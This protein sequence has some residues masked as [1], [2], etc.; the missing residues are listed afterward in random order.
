[1]WIF[2]W[3][4]FLLILN[5]V[6]S[7]DKDLESVDCYSKLVDKN[8]LQY[9]VWCD[10]KTSHQCCW[11]QEM[12][13]KNYDKKYGPEQCYSHSLLEIGNL[14]KF[15][16]DKNTTVINPLQSCEILITVLGK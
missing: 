10:R 11:I 3:T 4:L 12:C 9:R 13:W 1:M 7:D 8:S 16:F 15:S 2:V 5:G 14:A 6:E